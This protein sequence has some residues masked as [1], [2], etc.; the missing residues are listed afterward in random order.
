MKLLGRRERTRGT[1]RR[2]G[3]GLVRDVRQPQALSQIVFSTMRYLQKTYLL[4]YLYT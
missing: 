3:P 1:K 4:T 2:E